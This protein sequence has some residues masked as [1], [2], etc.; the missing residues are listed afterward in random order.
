MARIDGLYW[1]VHHKLRL[2][3][4]LSSNQEFEFKNLACLETE[5]S[6]KIGHHYKLAS[7][8]D[9]EATQVTS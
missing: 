3:E 8:T 2:T 6:Y 5:A 4:H 1:I 9:Y 7:C